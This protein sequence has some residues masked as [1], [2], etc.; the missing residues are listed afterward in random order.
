MGPALAR[1]SS[2]TYFFLSSQ[3][4]NRGAEKA[5]TRLKRSASSSPA[6]RLLHSCNA[7]RFSSIDGGGGGDEQCE[8]PDASLENF[9]GEKGRKEAT[10]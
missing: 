7:R 6:S 3:Y 10:N 2:A 1:A 8:K 9:P 4:V 5:S